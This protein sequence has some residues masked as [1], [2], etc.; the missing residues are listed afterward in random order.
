MFFEW[1]WGFGKMSFFPVL[2][3]QMSYGFNN[4]ISRGRHT[5]VFIEDD[6]VLVASPTTF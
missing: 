6:H 1:L 3:F 2:S 5:Q 4:N